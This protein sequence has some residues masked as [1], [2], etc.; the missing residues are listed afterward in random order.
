MSSDNTAARELELGM[1]SMSLGE[2]RDETAN[3][4]DRLEKMCANIIEAIKDMKSETKGAEERA[5]VEKKEREHAKERVSF[6][7][8]APEK[9]TGNKADQTYADWAFEFKAY[10]TSANRQLKKILEWE[11]RS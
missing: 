4:L 2:S 11:E 1:Q 8:R 7:Q 6:K 9:F 5:T 10:A 3:R